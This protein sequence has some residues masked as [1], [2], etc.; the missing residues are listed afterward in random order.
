MERGYSQTR[1][2]RIWAAMKQRCYNKNSQN[3]KNYGARGITICKEWLNDF[4][5]FRKW[6]LEHGYQDPS[7]A[8]G[9]N[10]SKALTIDRIDDD[11]GYSP[12]NC[13]WLTLSDN[14]SKKRKY[15]TCISMEARFFMG[16]LD[17][18]C[19]GVAKDCFGSSSW[20]DA[21]KIRDFIAFS[22][23]RK[24]RIKKINFIRIEDIP[25]AKELAVN[26]LIALKHA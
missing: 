21:R 4:E 18:F 19:F 6:A 11:K 17:R 26:V 7:P 8:W 2:Y 23:N 5:A 1:L 3:Y 10:R 20:H 13:Q 14:L 22:I 24:F 12:E 9:R 16:W 15:C 25:K